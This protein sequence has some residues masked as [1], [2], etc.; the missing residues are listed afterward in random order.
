MM[1]VAIGFVAGFTFA[2][3]IDCPECEE[4]IRSILRKCK[5]VIEE[6]FKQKEEVE[7]TS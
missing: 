4:K 6:E 1:R 2:K 7:E 3:V 5:D